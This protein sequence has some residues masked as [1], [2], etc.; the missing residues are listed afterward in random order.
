MHLE[1]P[2]FTYY[3]ARLHYSLVFIRQTQHE[4]IAST[5]LQ[6][7]ITKSRF[8]SRVGRNHKMVNLHYK[9]DFIL[10]IDMVFHFVW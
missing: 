4:L 2:I 5:R 3:R 10:T 8:S 6:L 1:V 9:V 7:L